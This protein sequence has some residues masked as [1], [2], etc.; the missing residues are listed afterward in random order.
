MTWREAD[1]WDS[2]LS[3]NHIEVEGKSFDGSEYNDALIKGFFEDR[4]GDI[5]FIDLK[6]LDFRNHINPL[7]LDS[8]HIINAN[9]MLKFISNYHDKNPNNIINYDMLSALG[10]FLVAQVD[11]IFEDKYRRYGTEEPDM[12]NYIES[13]KEVF[14]MLMSYIDYNNEV[15]YASNVGKFDYYTI[16]NDN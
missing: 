7:G 10:M 2:T 15:L 14:K 3:S 13:H 9:P 6:K 8:W 16:A 1:F 11:A 12:G 4:F 5:S